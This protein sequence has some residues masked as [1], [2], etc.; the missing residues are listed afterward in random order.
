[1]GYP[2]IGARWCLALWDGGVTDPLQTRPSPT[3]LNQLMNDINEILDLSN[4]TVLMC[5]HDTCVR[6]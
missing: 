1:M 3:E 2:K 6:L 4:V 5:M